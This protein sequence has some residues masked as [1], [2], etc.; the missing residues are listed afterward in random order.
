MRIPSIILIASLSLTV[1]ACNGSGAT[2]D[3]L[4]S[5]QDGDVPEAC[6]AR[7]TRSTRPSGR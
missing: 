7:A 1:L 4:V 2:D 3:D 5:V 6:C